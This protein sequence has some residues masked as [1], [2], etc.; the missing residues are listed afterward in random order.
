[1]TSSSGGGSPRALLPFFCCPV[2]GSLRS[3]THTAERAVSL[4]ST[5]R[6]SRF[7]GWS[8]CVRRGRRP[9]PKSERVIEHGPV[10][11]SRCSPTHTAERAVS[12]CSTRPRSRF[13]GW[14]ACVRRGRRPRPKSE[15]VIE[16]GPVRGS[17]RSPTHTAERAVSLCSTRPRSRFGGWSA[18]VRRG[19]R[20]R[21]RS[22]RPHR[23]RAGARFALL[24]YA[25]GRAGGLALLD[26]PALQVWWL[27]RVRPSR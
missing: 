27:E 11:G 25:H 15:R 4:R 10:R 2:R 20:P 6:R 12:L 3:P 17:L 13:G 16:H 22:R 8:A 24:T 14:S 26:T 1:M 23:T 21:P 7:G 9:R 5:R 19:R 18:C